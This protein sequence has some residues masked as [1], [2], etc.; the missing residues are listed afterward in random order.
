MSTRRKGPPRNGTVLHP[1]DPGSRGEI[2]MTFYGALIA[3][4]H[5]PGYSTV[6]EVAR[7]LAILT[8]A[9]DTRSSVR[10]NLRTDDDSKALIAALAV[11]EAMDARNDAGDGWTLPPDE[12]EALHECAARLDEALSRVS[13]AAYDEARKFVDTALSRAAG[14]AS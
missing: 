14:A 7:Q 5:T 8:A 11:V 4:A 12:L 10:I 3:L 9:I 13:F 1:M 2:A 6:N